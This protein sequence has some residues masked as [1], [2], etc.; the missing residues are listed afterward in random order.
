MAHKKLSDE[1]PV[2]QFEVDGYQI[3][4]DPNN[5]NWYKIY[6]HT[7]TGDVV[8][9]NMIARD[10]YALVKEAQTIILKQDPDSYGQRIATFYGMAD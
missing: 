4:G 5:V 8:E 6:L 1:Q 7:D 2:A 10:L 9:V 3:T